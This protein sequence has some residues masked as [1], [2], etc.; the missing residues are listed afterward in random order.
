MIKVSGVEKRFGDFV[1]LRSIDFEIESGKI[2]GLVGIN[3]AGKST[4]LRTLAGIYRADKGE[5]TYDG[6]PV[7]DNPLVKRRIVFVADEL[8]L[9]NGRNMQ[10]MARQYDRLYGRFNY[11][12]FSELSAAF[13]LDIK[14]SHNTFS[15]GMR[16]QAATILALS[17]EPDY[18]FFDETFDG[19]DPFK[20]GY[21][22]RLIA[23]DVKSRG[24]TAIITSHSLRELEDICD[25]LSVLDK[26][27]LVFDCDVGNISI[28]AVMVQIAFDED[29]GE[30]K[31]S[32][33]DIISFVKRGSV[34]TLVLR[35]EEGAVREALEAMSP[36][37]L[38][39]LPL[40]L[41][42]AFNME[43]SSRGVNSLLFAKEGEEAHR[44]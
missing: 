11:K 31:F 21:I 15:K 44:E 39:A 28:G 12:K 36:K 32:D 35:G 27:G 10:S 29:F 24:A 42:E 41:E 14:K 18:I 7:F 13:D 16:R 43:L 8:Y 26:G 34:A 25:K 30:E 17:V 5:V 2:Y 23:E 6:T 1:A 22:K 37:L 38:E 9:P 3:G 33:F 40:T 19:L 4:L 20:R